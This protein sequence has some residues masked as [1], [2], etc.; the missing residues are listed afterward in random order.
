MEN[1]DAGRTRT[2]AHNRGRSRTARAG[3]QWFGRRLRTRS[4]CFGTKRLFVDHPTEPKCADLPGGCGRANQWSLARTYKSPV[5]RASA[6]GHEQTGG[7]ESRT[8]D[9]ARCSS[10]TAH[11]LSPPLSLTRTL[12]HA[13]LGHGEPQAHRRSRD[14]VPTACRCASHLT[15]PSTSSTPPVK[16]SNACGRRKTDVVRVRHR[17]SG[18]GR[19][20]CHGSG[21]GLRAWRPDRPRP[22]AT[23][24]GV[25][26][27]SST[28]RARR[29]LSRPHLPPS[30][31]MLMSRAHGPPR[32]AG[33]D[34]N[35]GVA[36]RSCWPWRT[37][38]C[39]FRGRGSSSSGRG[40]RSGSR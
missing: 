1:E 38:P 33:A 19:R 3:H 37:G 36:G 26:R 17:R 6:G 40:L 20:A 16:Q 29:R 21:G 28:L 30:G 12:Q 35:L 39:A 13:S 5:G 22:G 7:R 32:H 14:F 8:A 2:G 34:P 31:A 15:G 25:T 24:S 4:H 18:S 23:M 10:Q 9:E 27:R 11:R